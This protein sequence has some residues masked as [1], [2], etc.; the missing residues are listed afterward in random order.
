[1]AQ[2]SLPGA[3]S[4]AGSVDIKQHYVLGSNKKEGR[5]LIKT[6]N[7]KV[8][9]VVAIEETVNKHVDAIES[10]WITAARILMQVDTQE[11]YRWCGFE[12]FNGWLHAR[13]KKP[14]YMQR[15]VKVLRRAKTFDLSDAA[16]KALGV[17]KCLIALNAPKAHQAELLAAAPGCNATVLA[18]MAKSMKGISNTGR[19]L[20]TGLTDADLEFANTTLRAMDLMMGTDANMRSRFLALF[21]NMNQ[22]LSQLGYAKAA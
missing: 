10:T 11:M 3:F 20:F 6:Q 5:P 7:D 9:T 13:I 8:S 4:F 12:D 17:T 19:L 1:L 18:A 14:E 22:T 21:N 15:V 16:L 2:V